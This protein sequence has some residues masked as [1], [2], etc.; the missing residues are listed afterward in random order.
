MYSN[1]NTNG[2]TQTSYPSYENYPYG[3]NTQ[4]D[5]RFVGGLLAPLF[6]GGVAG[7]AIGYN[8]PNYNQGFIPAPYPYPYQTPMYTNNY[9]YPYY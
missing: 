2:Y 7:Y 1:N 3:Y 4:N 6:L 9:Y 5:D 8:R